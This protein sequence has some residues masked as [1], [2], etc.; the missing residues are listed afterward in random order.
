MGK[1]EDLGRCSKC[2]FEIYDGI[3]CKWLLLVLIIIIKAICLC[4]VG[5]VALLCI[6]PGH[7]LILINPSAKMYY[8]LCTLFI[9]IFSDLRKKTS[10][11]YA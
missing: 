2:D 10:K 8:A 4:P 11:Q 9:L 7:T 6:C 1:L 3:V 5:A